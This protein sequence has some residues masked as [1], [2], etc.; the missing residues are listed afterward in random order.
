MNVRLRRLPARPLMAGGAVT[1]FVSGLFVGCVLGA[2]AA[3][4]AGAVIDWHRQ[5]GFTLGV[6][7]D[8]LPLGEQIGLL[9]S[10]HDAW[11]LVVPISGVAFG[12]LNA[13]IG[14]L[15]AGLMAGLF[16]R[17]TLGVVLDVEVPEA[18]R[19]QLAEPKAP[20]AGRRISVR[21]GL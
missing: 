10:V 15:A 21:R 17:L 4:F 9:Q 16:N 5:L 20:A 6:T 13:L 18:E 7:E 12:L 1:G 2:L 19:Q 14:F 3:W 8:L 11:W